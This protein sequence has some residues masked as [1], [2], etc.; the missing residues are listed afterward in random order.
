M[1]L[2][3]PLPE[4]RFG[5]IGLGSMGA[6]MAKNLSNAVSMLRV[7]DIAGTDERAPEGTVCCHSLEE[8]IGSCDTIFLSLP[9]GK[10]VIQTAQEMVLI[11]EHSCNTLVDTSTIGVDAVKHVEPI[12]EKA[13]IVYLDCPVSGGQSGAQAGTLTFMGSGSESRFR[14]LDEIL[15]SMA[16]NIF[17]VGNRCGQGQAM[18]LLNN[19]LSGT[20]ML[21]TSEAYAFGM[22]QELDPQQMFEVLNVSTGVNS[23]TL[24]KFPKQVVTNRYAAGFSNTMMS[25]DISLFRESVLK[26][27]TLSPVGKIV[28]EYW[29]QFSELEPLKDFTQIYPFLKKKH[30]NKE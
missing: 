29:E 9:D 24:D 20:A 6:P 5:F 11:E 4:E 17:Y 8:I 15:Q 25:K 19:F 18:K 23:A 30:R 16:A 26:A 3:S 21:A 10:S 13:K 14:E 28:Q 2:P 7:F 27:Q 1:S 12:V 22:S